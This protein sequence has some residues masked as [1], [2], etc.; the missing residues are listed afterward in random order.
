MANQAAL[1]LPPKLDAYVT[2]YVKLTA[3]QRSQLL[4]GQPVT[5]MLDADPVRDVA[6]FGAIWVNAPSSRY[7]AVAQDVE[8]FERGGSFRITKRIRS[9]RT[10]KADVEALARRLALQYVTGYLWPQAHHPQ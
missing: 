9:K 5:Q 6:V 7:V 1:G 3:Q 10:A 4:A 2:K 8:R